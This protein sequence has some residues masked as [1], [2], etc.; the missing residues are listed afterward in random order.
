MAESETPAGDAAASAE[1]GQGDTWRAAFDR[2]LADR[3]DDAVM[4]WLFRGLVAA[5]VAVVALDY[6]ELSTA[7]EQRALPQTVLPTAEPLPPS[8]R[9]STTAPD[10]PKGAPDACGNE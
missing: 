5:T 9:T 8:K 2:W 3:P 6:A 7:L 1:A 10:G 4:R